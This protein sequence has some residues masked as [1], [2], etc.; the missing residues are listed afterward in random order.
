[1]ELAGLNA[2]ADLQNADQDTPSSAVISIPQLYEFVKTYEKYKNLNSIRLSYREA[3]IET[4]KKFSKEKH[5][6]DTL[7][8]IY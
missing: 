8:A 6:R 1:M 7:T 4:Q 2:G 3:E 5:F